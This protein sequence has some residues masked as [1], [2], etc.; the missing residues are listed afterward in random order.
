M[1]RYTL[2]CNLIAL[3]THSFYFS[4]HSW[5]IKDILRVDDPSNCKKIACQ[6]SFH[7]LLLLLLLLSLPITKLTLTNQKEKRPTH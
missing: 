5:H 2:H 4:N 7:I 6:L 3:V 1:N